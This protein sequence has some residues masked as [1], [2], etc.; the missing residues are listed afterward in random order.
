MAPLRCGVIF[1][2]LLFLI[3]AS[4]VHQYTSSLSAALERAKLFNFTIPDKPVIHV[5]GAT[6]DLEKMADWA[7]GAG[8]EV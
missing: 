4:A 3:R 6:D 7:D 8:L 1:V 2:T 5:L